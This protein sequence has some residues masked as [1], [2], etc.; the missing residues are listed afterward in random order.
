MSRNKSMQVQAWVDA[1]HIAALAVYFQHL[2]ILEKRRISS[3]TR[4]AIEVL[5]TILRRDNEDFFLPESPDHAYE[6]L[7]TLGFDV[8]Q[9]KTGSRKRRIQKAIS[10]EGGKDAGDVRNEESLAEQILELA[11]SQPDRVTALEAELG[12]LPDETDA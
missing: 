10:N 8:N 7:S 11:S 3:V 1:E 9:H 5:L 12:G 2:G 6:V 4:T